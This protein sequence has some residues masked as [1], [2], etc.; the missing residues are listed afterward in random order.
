MY[1]STALRSLAL[2][3]FLP[4]FPFMVCAQNPDSG[5]VEIVQDEKVAEMVQRYTDSQNGKIKGYR[6]QV[7]FGAEKMKAKDA[8]SKFLSKNPDMKAYELFETPYFKIRAGNFRTK[9]EAYQF[10]QK[11]KADFPG[12]FIVED[13]IELPDL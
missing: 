7:F 4:L 13:E 8:K 9:L 11:I 5:K 6:V 1:F 10:L 12:A 3:L 2:S